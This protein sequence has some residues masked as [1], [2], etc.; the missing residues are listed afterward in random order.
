MAAAWWAESRPAVRGRCSAA[1]TTTAPAAMPSAALLRLVL[2][3]F[4]IDVPPALDDAARSSASACSSQAPAR[5]SRCGS[6]RPRA[7]VLAGGVA[8]AAR[9]PRRPP[10]E[11]LDALL[12]RRSPAT[13]A[14]GAPGAV[15]LRGPGVARPARRWP[16]RRARGRARPVGAASAP[17]AELRLL[18]RLRLALPVVPAERLAELAWAADDGPLVAWTP[19]GVHA[20]GAPTWSTCRAAD[21]PR[22][23]AALA[24]R[25]GRRPARPRSAPASSRP[26]L[27]A[28]FAFTEG[29]I[30]AVAGPRPRRRRAGA[31]GALDRDARLGG[32]PPPARARARARG[33]ADHPGFTLD[34]L[35]LT[36]DTARAAARAG[37]ARRPPARR[38]RRLGLPPPAAARP[39]RGGAVRR[40]AR[41]GKTM[42]AEALAAR[43][44]RRTS[45]A[46]TSRRSS[47]STSA[48]PRRTWPSPST[49]P[50]AA[51]RC[52]SSTRPTRCSASAPRSATRTTATPTSRS[53]TCCSGSRRFTGLVVLAT[54]PESA[55]DEAFLRRL[56]FVVRFELPDAEPAQAA[57]AALVPA[58]A[59][60]SR[61]STGTRSPPPSWRAGTS[62][63]A[64]LAAAYLAAPTAAS[65]TPEH[66][67]HALRREYEKLGTAW[68][69]LRLG[70][71]GMT[72]G[73]G[74]DGASLRVEVAM[75]RRIR[76]CSRARSR[77]AW[78]PAV[79]G[80]EP[81]WPTPWP[82]PCAGTAQRRGGAADGADQGP[83]RSP[84][85]TRC[86]ASSRRWSSSS[87][88]RPSH[89]RVPTASR[90]GR[91]ARRSAP[92]STRRGPRGGLHAQARA[93]RHRRARARR[94]D[95]D[96]ARHLATAGGARDADAAGR[97]VAA[98][99]PRRSL[100]GGGGGT[101]IP[102]GK[103]PLVLFAW[104][105]PHHSRPAHS[106]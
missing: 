15:V 103:L 32:G 13:C 48:R 3:P 25:A 95:H 40:A 41:H 73:R 104:G 39:G 56:R 51:A 61:S 70:G 55:L 11:R 53:T 33:G 6:R 65:I 24:R 75:R 66:V 9:P 38:A 44:A 12:A 27:A 74:R 34:D 60:R 10:P 19:A 14:R 20:P 50:S 7:L 2:E 100:L 98:R 87:T 76:T 106:R 18:A 28:R 47:R 26:A 16:P 68:P 77:R 84:S 36:D 31:A 17:A 52:S 23:R 88:T 96:G 90:R 1:R 89:P 81:P 54:Q 82:T 45:T 62:R 78:P 102:A 71:G 21:A 67:E 97:H 35:V 46:S 59:R 80:A 101:A 37:R 22:A 99:R 85:T 42:A 5:A 43:A 30:D 58:R 93:R 4:G 8:G 83:A 72:A 94:P 57:V 63:S 79:P 92:R 49:R 29:D 91:R 105:P 64:A 86:S 69:G